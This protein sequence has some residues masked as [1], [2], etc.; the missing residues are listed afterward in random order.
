MGYLYDKDG[1][2]VYD[3]DGNAIVI[4][5]ADYNSS[6]SGAEIDAFIQQIVLA[7]FVTNYTASRISAVTGK[8]VSTVTFQSNQALQAWE[9]RADGNGHGSGDLVGNGNS[10]NAWTNAQFDVENEE[11]TWGDKIY[12]INVYGQNTNGEWSEYET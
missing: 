8:D 3:R 12:R 10:L 11:L 9:A 7:L 2:Q 4:T 5:G 6:Y 1:Y